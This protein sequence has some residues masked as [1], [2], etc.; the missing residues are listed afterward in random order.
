MMNK[1]VMEAVL[2]ELNKS[3]EVA[4]KTKRAYFEFSSGR[5]TEKAM[6]DI[7]SK[8]KEELEGLVDFIDTLI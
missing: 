7:L 8:G 3:K 2:E 1:R 5:I 6:K 4:E